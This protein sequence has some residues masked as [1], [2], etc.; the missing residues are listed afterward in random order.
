ME[1]GFR[2]NEK[3]EVIARNIITLFECLYNNELVFSADFNPA[4]SA[5]PFL[6]F[7]TVATESGT[8]VFRWTDQDGVIWSETANIV[9]T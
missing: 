3:G 7:Y 8:L 2:R 5:N 4:V 6:S 9:V 1:S